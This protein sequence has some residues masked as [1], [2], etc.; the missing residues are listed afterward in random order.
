MTP[1]ELVIRIETAGGAFSLEDGELRCRV[2][3]GAVSA[4]TAAALR[5]HW[6]H[7]ARLMGAERARLWQLIGAADAEN[8]GGA[9]AGGSGGG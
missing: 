5:R 3:R 9:G 4:E 2:P 1:G 8:G 6:Q 7:G